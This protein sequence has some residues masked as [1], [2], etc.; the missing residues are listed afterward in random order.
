MKVNKTKKNKVVK[1]HQPLPKRELT[2]DDFM[3]I[4][5]LHVLSG[6]LL[7]VLDKL[8]GTHFFNAKLKSTAT[9][10]TELLEPIFDFLHSRKVAKN[11]E[12]EE[13]EKEV[14]NELFK[15]HLCYQLTV[16]HL[17]NLPIEKLHLAP[18]LLEQLLKN[19]IVIEQ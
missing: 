9:V 16:E 7:D 12:E 14:Y 15:L 10:M 1:T 5:Q 6:K 19:Q 2:H 3:C 13:K 4:S 17:Y 8:R 11:E 18:A